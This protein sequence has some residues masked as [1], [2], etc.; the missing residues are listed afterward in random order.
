MKAIFCF[1]ALLSAILGIRGI[2]EQHETDQTLLYEQKALRKAV[3]TIMVDHLS[4][5]MRM[6]EIL[7]TL[8][9]EKW[10][11]GS[12]HL[13]TSIKKK[14][15]E[16]QAVAQADLCYA[17]ERAILVKHA[18]GDSEFKSA[19]MIDGK[20]KLLPS[21]LVKFDSIA[22]KEFE[23]VMYHYKYLLDQIGRSKTSTE[24]DTVA[25]LV[26]KK[27][28]PL[29]HVESTSEQEVTQTQVTQTP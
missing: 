24:L 7:S 13:P 8:K 27:L 11:D 29:F 19:K 20:L 23:V 5:E 28:K 21:L 1:I 10:C 26:D 12:R 17:L 4:A 25:S 6:V 15:S 22:K 9:M 14:L 2:N 16:N 18:S 3:L